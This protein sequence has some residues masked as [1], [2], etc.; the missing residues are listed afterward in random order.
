MSYNRKKDT[1]NAIN[2]SIRLNR[3]NDETGERA[4]GVSV[5]LLA[6]DLSNLTEVGHAIANLDADMFKDFKKG[7][8]MG[9]GKIEIIDRVYNADTFGIVKD[10]VTYNGALE[11]ICV[12]ALAKILPSSANNLVYGNSYLDGKY[13]GAD[14]DALVWCDENA[15]FKIPYSIGY[16]DIK[17]R[18][19]DETWVI[20]TIDA[21]R[22]MVH[23][24]MEVYLKG[25]ADTLILRVIKE[26]ITNSNEVK[27]VT[28]FCKYFGYTT[29]S[30]GVTTNNYTWENIKADKD[31]MGQF[32]GFWSLAISLVKDGF[33]KFQS[34]Y[35]DGTV[36]TFT[37]SDKIRFIGLTEFV[38]D[39]NYLGRVNM[40]HNEIIPSDNM[41]TTLSW[42]SEG[43][44]KLPTL[45][46]TSKFIDGAI[47]VSGGKITGNAES[48]T[49][50]DNVV[51]VMYDEDMV[52]VTT[53]LN[54]IGY[55]DV[56]AELFGT[57]FH[58]YSIS[59]YCD[60]RG[61]AVVF[62]LE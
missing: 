32:V 55:E 59:Q 54:K 17:A 49:T 40:R 50:Y 33:N 44:A 23:T 11:R 57:Y 18:F 47:T 62:T 46:I 35:N 48:A 19:T 43:S 25:I 28:E 20:K 21:W 38:N 14:L 60:L 4:D 42:S 29:E 51:A 27:L 26:A 2:Y 1:A 39:M 24:T 36:P 34:K 56:S 61:N 41:Y 10:E 22:N 16:E 3:M 15:N 53:R 58:H 8:A 5:P 7:L 52:G 13:Y 12:K 31:L 30:Q 6:E 9:L 37:P 45:N